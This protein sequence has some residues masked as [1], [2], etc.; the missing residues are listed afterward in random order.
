VGAHLDDPGAV[1]DDDQ[2][3]HAHGAEAV[4]HEDRDPAVGRPIW[5]A[6]IA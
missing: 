6:A 5:G 3:S 2:V 1:Q 4:R